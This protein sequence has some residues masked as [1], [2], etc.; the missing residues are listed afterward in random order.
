MKQ[1]YFDEDFVKKVIKNNL[2]NEYS[3]KEK[4]YTKDNFN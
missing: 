1:D 4:E 3:N 2:V